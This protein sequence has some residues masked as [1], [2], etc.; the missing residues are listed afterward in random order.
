[1]VGTLSRTEDAL[2]PSSGWQQHTMPAALSW[3]LCLRLP[4]NVVASEGNLIGQFRYEHSRAS[5]GVR[6]GLRRPRPS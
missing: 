5:H 1:M 2:I 6:F 3:S 4:L